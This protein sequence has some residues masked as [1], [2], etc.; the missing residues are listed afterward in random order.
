[1]SKEEKK[2]KAPQDKKKAKAPSSK[3]AAKKNAAP[4]GKK[5]EVAKKG[6]KKVEKKEDKKVEEKKVVNKKP[7][8]PKV[9]GRGNKKNTGKKEEGKKKKVS[10]KTPAELPKIMKKEEKKVEV[11]KKK[12]KSAKKKNPL[13]VARPKSFH[14][15]G[16]LPPKRDLSR[17][18][19]WPK[20][21]QLQRKKKIM[22]QRLK[23]PA[24]INQ[25]NQT[26]DKHAAKVVMRLLKKYR[27]ET[28]SMRKTRRAKLAKAK[29]QGKKIILHK[30]FVVSQGS[31]R[32]THLVEQK[33]AKLVVI[34][35]DVD[36]IEH[37]IFLPTLC[38]KMNV[39]YCIVRGKARLG[40]LVHLKNCSTVALTQVRP[41]DKIAFGAI[42]SMC[43]NSYNK[44]GD[45]IV[46]NIG[47]GKL[48]LRSRIALQKRE[49]ALKKASLEKQKA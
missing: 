30:P 49:E 10:R 1:M 39:P 5:A 6:G 28:P 13:F 2:T 33:K 19:K 3:P 31:S 29:H 38:R 44:K 47:G 32:V 16:D 23:I 46:R 43:K 37:V 8:L 17:M 45:H 42:R 20:Y 7:T 40:K 18:V 24:M 12:K 36:P 34:A 4:K 26:L 35:N 25:F 11:V 41:S 15:G 48:G 27:P 22:Y 21:I 14:I 9:V